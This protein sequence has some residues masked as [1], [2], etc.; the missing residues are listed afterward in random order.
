MNEEKLWESYNN[1]LMSGDID[2][3]RK[4]LARYELFKKTLDV[5]GSIAECGVFKGAGWF[6]WL[7]LLTIYAP[8]ERKFVYGFD[9]FKGCSEN[10]LEF[11]K[12]ASKDFVEESSFNDINP[13]NLL[14][15][16][17]GYG[18][19]NG[20]LISGEVTESIPDF[21]QKNKG[22][23]FSLINL[24]FDTYEGTRVALENFVPLMSPGGIIILDEYGKEGW[25]ESDAVDEY[26]SKH[27]LQLK[28][29]RHSS[30]PTAYIEIPKKE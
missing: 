12:D 27:N 16:A 9:T 1:L 11:E 21:V 25:G 3:I 20:K 13:N 7:K 22:I 18:L 14:S 29:V 6:Y 19:N 30:L 24:D 26:I 2:R 10:L 4:L 17:I 28:S 5:P 23:R 15:Q 8:G